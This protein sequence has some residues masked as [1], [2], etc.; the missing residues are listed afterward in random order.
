LDKAQGRLQLRINLSI[1]TR[2]V[3]SQKQITRLYLHTI[4]DLF[5]GAI[6]Q[7]GSFL[8][9][10]AFERKSREIAFTTAAFINDTFQTNTDSQALLEFLQSVDAKAIDVASE[11]Y[12]NSVRL[13]I[14]PVLFL[15]LNLSR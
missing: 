6:L 9:P 1:K 11:Q 2:E 4:I 14:T 8:S 13:C 3:T 15:N 12:A 10:W 5:R 7:S